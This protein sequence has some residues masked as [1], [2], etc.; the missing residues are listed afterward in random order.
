MRKSKYAE[1]LI[2]YMAVNVYKTR[3]GNIYGFCIRINVG[4]SLEPPTILQI[5]RK[6]FSS[7]SEAE[8]AEQRF[9]NE[10]SKNKAE[11][12]KQRQDNMK[13]IMEYIKKGYKSL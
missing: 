1:R 13:E 10:I 11:Y 9:L 5:R 7:K 4:G 3:N 12:L 2:K 8:L 6:G